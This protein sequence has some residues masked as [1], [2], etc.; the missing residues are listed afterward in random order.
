[1]Q[2]AA[3]HR[4]STK[5]EVRAEKW[6]LRLLLLESNNFSDATLQNEDDDDPGNDEDD[7]DWEDDGERERE[8]ER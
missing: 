1:M 8:R 4:A 7:E 2:A 6:K 5:A 3:L